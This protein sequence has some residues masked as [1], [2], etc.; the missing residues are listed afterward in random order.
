MK[1]EGDHRASYNSL[2]NEGGNRDRDCH[3]REAEEGDAG[4]EGEGDMKLQEVNE[5]W[6]TKEYLK[7]WPGTKT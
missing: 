3:E 1:D 4:L 2:G 5:W 6:V 7:D